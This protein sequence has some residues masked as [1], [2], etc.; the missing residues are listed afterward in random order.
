M[1][2]RGK[3]AASSST[4]QGMNSF[5]QFE[6]RPAGVIAQTTGTTAAEEDFTRLRLKLFLLNRYE[7]GWCDHQ[8]S[9]DLT[10]PAKL[11]VPS[12]GL[13]PPPFRRSSG[14]G[15]PGNAA[16]T[17]RFS[18]LCATFSRLQPTAFEAAEV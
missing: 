1:A 7:F 15:N 3:A 4:R 13:N 16:G 17:S 9:G 10:A 5:E 2:S 12:L 8:L 11:L 14:V 6:C 18:R